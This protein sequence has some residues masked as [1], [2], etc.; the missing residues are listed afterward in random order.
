MLLL[1]LKH[2]L[3]IIY[4]FILE[5]ITHSNLKGMINNELKM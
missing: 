2:I 3:L 1:H 5:E 4:I